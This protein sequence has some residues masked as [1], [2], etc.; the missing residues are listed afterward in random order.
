MK[1]KI[2]IVG[3]LFIFF[4]SI[5]SNLVLALTANE[6]SKTENSIKEEP[7]S[8]YGPEPTDN[9]W[10]TNQIVN[11][12]FTICLIFSSTIVLEIQLRKRKK[13]NTTKMKRLA[14]KDKSWDYKKMETLVEKTYYA[15][16]NAWKNQDISQA[17][18]YITKE[19]KEQLEIKLNWLAFQER[20]NIVEEVQLLEVV[21]VSM[22]DDKEDK[23]DFV[24]FY[25]KGKMIRYVIDTKSG[26]IISGHGRNLP[27]TE[28]WQF[29]KGKENQWLLN[30]ILQ[31]DEIK[32]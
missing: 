24:W 32:K 19:F 8:N 12:I 6:S 14:V 31:E 9:S 10:A 7:Y 13:E 22:Y 3:I 15:I 5:N 21:P 27:F 1:Q 23:K 18:L 11:H 25:I 4:I 26:K 17:S 2:L 28:Y 16:Q 29:K 20:K 30:K